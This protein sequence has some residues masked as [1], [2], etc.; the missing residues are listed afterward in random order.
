M[1]WYEIL[2]YEH[3]MHSAIQSQLNYQEENYFHD[4]YF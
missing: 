2:K 1:I 3:E 4:S